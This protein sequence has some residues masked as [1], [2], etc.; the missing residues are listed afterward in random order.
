M[1]KKAS[2][3]ASQSGIG[4]GYFNLAKG[5]AMFL[6]LFGHS[7]TP[8]MEWKSVVTDGSWQLFQYAGDVLGGGIM[9]MFFLIS[10]YGFF[11]RKPKKTWKIQSSMLL[12]PYIITAILI[13]G[14]KFLLAVVKHRSFME[15]GGQYVL[16]YLFGLNAEGGGMLFGIPIESI[17]IF[18]FILAL[19]EGWMI[20]N[21]ILQIK[22]TNIQ[23]LLII[24]SG[25]VGCAM[26]RISSVWP[27]CLPLGMMTV[28]FLAVGERIR[29]RKLLEGHIQRSKL[30]FYIL[31]SLFCFAFGRVNM[32]LL[33]YRLWVIDLAGSIA[34]GILLLKFYCLLMNLKWVRNSVITK[35]FENFGFYSINILTIHA[36]EKVILPWYRLAYFIPDHPYVCTLICLFCRI[37]II[38]ITGYVLAKLK[39]GYKKMRKK[40]KRKGRRL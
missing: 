13:L 20:Y 1:E 25:A 39:R 12:K 19:F 30:A 16:T 6:I 28:W 33:D 3:F 15:N 35:L 37:L 31:L 17:S 5:F 11:K 22:D 24:L 38:G 32:V 9:A 29:D 2:V 27:Y 14:S 36:Y 4:M 7:M 26:G 34:V 10:G 40:N 23:N 18:W 21:Q 8:F